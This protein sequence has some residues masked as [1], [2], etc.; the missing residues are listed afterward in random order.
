MW[1]AMSLRFGVHSLSVVEGNSVVLKGAEV[2]ESG[3]GK[4]GSKRAMGHVLG[5]HEREGGGVG[6]IHRG[7]HALLSK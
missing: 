5:G 4:M 2:R 1:L 6:N 7:A 3:G